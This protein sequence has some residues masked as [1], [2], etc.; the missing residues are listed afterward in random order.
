VLLGVVE[1]YA[2]CKVRV[3][4]GYR[5]QEEQGRPQGAVSRHKHGSILDLPRQGEELLAEFV[6]RLMLGAHMI[7]DFRGAKFYNNLG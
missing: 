4:S 2:L 7:A 3:C 5:T 1:C 6:C